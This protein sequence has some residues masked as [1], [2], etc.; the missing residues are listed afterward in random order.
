MIPSR[1]VIERAKDILSSQPTVPLSPARLDRGQLSLCAAAA[2]ALAGIENRFGSNAAEAFRRNA[3]SISTRELEMEFE[4]L[5]WGTAICAE[6]RYCNDAAS[7]ESRL[8]V[9]LSSLEQIIS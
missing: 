6:L 1:Y 8:G 2:L 5:E 9:I 7:P 3:A 4:K